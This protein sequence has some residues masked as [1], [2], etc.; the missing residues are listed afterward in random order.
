MNKIIILGNGQLGN[1]IY[2]NWKLIEYQINVIDYPQFDITNQQMIKNIIINYDIIIN[3]AAYTLVDKAESEQLKCFEI[4]SI[5]PMMLA[6]ECIKYNKKLIHI[7]TEAVFG[8]NDPNYTP[9]KENDIKN[10]VNVYAKSKYLTDEFIQN[11]INENILI[12]RPGWLFGP[13]NNHNFI[14]KIKTV[15]LNKEKIKVVTDQIGTLTFVGDI[16]IAI[17]AFL[18]NK[19][20][21]GI[22]NIGDV[23]Y[24][25]RY[26]IACFV[27]DQINAN[28]I[29]EKCLSEDFKRTANVAKNSCLDCSKIKQ[30][31]SVFNKWQDNVIKVLK[32]GVN[33]C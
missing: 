29:I 33:I 16:L 14:E 3:A 2:K 13:N 28:C 5:G 4:N 17:E 32:E 31:I 15:M 9:L 6:S 30:Y 8:S 1:F 27:K 21:S 18:T 24:P 19:L 20:P 25:S 11:L 23:G 26:D 22:Y 12:L 7:S 10:P